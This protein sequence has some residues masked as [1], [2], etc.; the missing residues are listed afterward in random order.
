MKR[1]A[2][3]R[4]AFQPKP[5]ERV[6]VNE[7]HTKAR[8]IIVVLAIVIAVVAFTYAIG[9]MFHV[10]SGW[11][12]IEATTS[13]EMN[14]SQDFQFDYYLGG[15]GMSAAAELK[16]IT[17]L[18]TQAT[19]TAYNAFNGYEL[20]KGTNN[21]FFLNRNVNTPVQ[22]DPALY[23]AF[24]LVERLGS[25]Y[26]YLAPV[27]AEYNSLFFC[28][29]DWETEGFDPYQNEDVRAF[30][31]QAAAYAR[32]PE[33]VSLELMGENTLQLTVSEEY[34]AFAREYGI[35]NLVDFYWMKDAFIIDYLAQVM[36]ESGF[37][38]GAISSYDGYVRCL[39][40]DQLSY[41]F[42]FY[43]QYDGSKLCKA[44]RLTYTGGT[45]LV[46]LHSFRLNAQKELYYYQF[47]DGTVRAP[48][49]DLADGLNKS[50]VPAMI[51]TSRTA[52][53]AEQLLRLLPYYAADTLDTAG[54]QTLPDEGI[55]PLYCV[56]RSIITT[57]PDVAVDE[58]LDGYE[59]LNATN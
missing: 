13:G 4:T 19:E 35:V 23:Q 57:S 51:G 32:S 58:V 39:S 9:S 24:E 56:E 6:E 14:C 54:L 38:R 8:T 41:S 18:Y 50:A 31:G 29:E 3:D 43:D 10:D 49:V 42:H 44:A 21:L 17:A 15:S 26:V 1:T 34:L 55:Y 33:H 20:G 48:Y 16:A 37:N 7:S 40:A 27:Y 45:S 53:C 30:M 5:V 11:R 25:R 52:G 59:V 2:P 28:T 12:T 47:A 36:E 22:V 46:H